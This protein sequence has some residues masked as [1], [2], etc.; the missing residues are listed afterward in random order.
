M[1]LPSALLPHSLAKKATR[2]RPKQKPNDGGVEKDWKKSCVF[3]GL[4]GYQR[5]SAVQHSSRPAADDYLVYICVCSTGKKK[6]RRYVTL[7][8]TANKWR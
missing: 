6:C 5:Q 8:V 4:F 2:G 1:L 3:P 7:D